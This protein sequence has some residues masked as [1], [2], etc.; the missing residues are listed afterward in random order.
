M[1]GSTAYDG[2]CECGGLI[3]WVPE[4]GVYEDVEAQKYHA[5]RYA[6]NSRLGL[7]VPPSTPSKLR[8]A[9][10]R[11]PKEKKVW[12]EGRALHCAMF[13]PERF[14]Q[15]YRVAEQCIGFTKAGSR[16]QSQGSVPVHGGFVCKTHI[17]QYKLDP[18]TVAIS[19]GDLEMVKGVARAMREHPLT[20]AF[21]ESTTAKREL[22]LIWDQVIPP[23]AVGQEAIA[24]RCK[25]RI[26][27]Y[28]PEFFGGLPMDAKGVRGADLREFV[29]QAFYNGYL[30]QSVLYRMALAYHGLPA[31]TY[32][33]VALEK[34]RP[35]DLQV[36]W[37][38]DDATG[39]LWQP[40]EPVEHISKTVFLLLRL[41]HECH[42]LDTW[43]GFPEEVVTLTLPEWAW[44]ANDHQCTLLQ[45]RLDNLTTEK[46][47]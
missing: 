21:M 2:A 15:E 23:L 46:G 42:R 26:D 17:D 32:A 28:D 40:G 30:R 5:C 19:P 22:S 24:V 47:T 39:A 36:Y 37:I 4:P 34:E 35:H 7:L 16:C 13:E 3:E 38:G 43:P 18:E 33:A 6:S 25:A 20:R 14:A 12:K 44:S 31:R 45:E 9:M 41:W 8:E 27:W 11:P 1:A 29:K 10:E